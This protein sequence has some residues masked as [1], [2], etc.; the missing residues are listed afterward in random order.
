LGFRSFER[1]PRNRA[2]LLIAFLMIAVTAVSVYGWHWVS[3]VPGKAARVASSL[4]GKA[5]SEWVRLKAFGESRNSS[6]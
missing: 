3:H 6:P 5:S 2:P 1:V 4:R